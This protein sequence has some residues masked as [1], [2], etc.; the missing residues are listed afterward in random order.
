MTLTQNQIADSVI[1]FVSLIGTFA[2]LNH[3]HTNRRRSAL[4]NSLLFLFWLVATVLALRTPMWMGYDDQ[5]YQKIA[6]TPAI[7]IPLALL[8]LTEA[9]LRRHASR[10]A[11]IFIC[12]STVGFFGLNIARGLSDDNLIAFSGFFFVAIMMV[13]FT[14]FF[15]DRSTLSTSENSL[16]DAFIVVSIFSAPLV[17][18]D[19]REQIGYTPVRLGSIGILLTIYIFLREAGPSKRKR[20]ITVEVLRFVGRSILLGVGIWALVVRTNNMWSQDLFMAISESFAFILLFFILD[21]ISPL[22][23]VIRQSRIHGWIIDNS[24]SSLS[25]FSKAL[26]T[27]SELE[28]ARLL[29]AENLNHYDLNTL[30]KFLSVHKVASLAQIRN[31]WVAGHEARDQ[32]IDLLESHHVNH[33]CMLSTEPFIVLVFTAPEVGRSEFGEVDYQVVQKIGSLAVERTY[34]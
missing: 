12:L 17:V 4:E 7:L 23:A 13:A 24:L 9:L 20:A 6:M 29:Y 25:D 22:G 28:G 21:K 27:L 8:F 31:T 2:F 16:I 19:F 10:F 26:Q 15:R 33:I 3:L 30:G 32:L 11:K 34:L 14:L 5:F 18:T 1:N